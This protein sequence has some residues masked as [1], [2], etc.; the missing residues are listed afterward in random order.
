MSIM[1][2]DLIP[3]MTDAEADIE[4]A[5]TLLVSLRGLRL[6]RDPKLSERAARREQAVLRELQDLQKDAVIR[7]E[8]PE[9]RG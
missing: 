8:A 1:V 6:C 5:Q 2:T 3:S 7:S 9:I 4:I